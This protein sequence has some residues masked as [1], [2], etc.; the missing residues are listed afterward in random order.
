MKYERN[1]EH[2]VEKIKNILGENHYFLTSTI[3]RKNHLVLKPIKDLK[4]EDIDKIN[5]RVKTR[6][7]IRHVGFEKPFKWESHKKLFSKRK[8]TVR[9]MVKEFKRFIEFVKQIIPEYFT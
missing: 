9:K 6:G 2:I 8:D 7:K 5:E 3:E 1:P 4:R